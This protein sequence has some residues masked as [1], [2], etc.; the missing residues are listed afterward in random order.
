[1]Q[2][3]QTCCPTIHPSIRAA[4]VNGVLS[5]P[6]NVDLRLD[7]FT[8]AFGAFSLQQIRAAYTGDCIRVRRSTD[9]AEQDFG[10]VS[11]EL[12]TASI[13]SFCGAGDGLVPTWYGQDDVGRNATQAV[14]SSQPF[15]VRSGVLCTNE[16]G[17]PAIDFATN[18]FMRANAIAASMSGTS[19]YSIFS[20]SS[21]ASYVSNAASLAFSGSSTSVVYWWDNSGGN[22][23]R[24]F[25]GGGTAF[26][27]NNVSAPTGTQIFALIDGASDSI[28]RGSAAI[29]A[30]SLSIA[31]G[32]VTTL[33]IGT[34]VS[35]QFGN[36]KLTELLIYPVD[37]ASEYSGIYASLNDSWGV[38]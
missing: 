36:D 5:V 27:E 19:A 1:M 4:A 9:S 14:A 24:L 2:L 22:G 35:A 31:I 23:I 17:N 8:G 10:F 6:N 13:L 25:A 37:Y 20:V 18:R 3:E 29:G 33:E 38:Y 15:I 34:F 30:P 21:R 16:A 28:Y 7:L 26:N 11:G 12:D 32:T